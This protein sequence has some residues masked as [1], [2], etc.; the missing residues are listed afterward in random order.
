MRW[1][2]EWERRDDRNRGIHPSVAIAAL[3]ARQTG[4]RRRCGRRFAGEADVRPGE[5]LWDLGPR[6]I[7]FERVLRPD[8]VATVEDDSNE[9]AGYS[10][11]GRRYAI[12]YIRGLRDAVYA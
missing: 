7:G 10:S 2:T 5:R 11:L 9:D 4:R 12:V 8:P 3:E 1:S 6:D